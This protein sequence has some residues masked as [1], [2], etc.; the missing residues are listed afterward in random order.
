MKKYPINFIKTKE[1]KLQITKDFVPET[2]P[3][4]EGNEDTVLFAKWNLYERVCDG[5]K[6]FTVLYD[7][8]RFYDAYIIAGHALETCAMLSYIK[9][10]ETDVE[11]RNR[12][13]L[14]LARCLVGNLI[15]I[16][17]M[18]QDL[19]NVLAWNAYAAWMRSFASYGNFI[20]KDKKNHAEIFEQLKIREGSNSEK[21]KLLKRNY[22]PPHIEE[23]INLFSEKLDGV[24]E[25]K[26][27]RFY[28]KYCGFKHSN[29]LEC[30]DGELAD[31]QIED[32]II[33]VFMLVTYLSMANL[34][35]YKHPA[36]I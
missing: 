8:N 35:P 25:E 26:F 15:E 33:L 29:M 14:Y 7:N 1:G 2:K 30:L 28:F 22:D 32:S 23:Y 34:E 13:N 6:S 3:H 27:K 31:Y 36:G 10:N 24:D 16:L 11:Q 4:F 9:D 18:S 12:F 21:V 17:E 20:I 19:S 5:I